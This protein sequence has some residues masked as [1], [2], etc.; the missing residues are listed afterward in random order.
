MP[1]KEAK[2]I[3]AVLKFVNIKKSSI[4][5]KTI[6]RRDR[7]IPLSTKAKFDVQ[8]FLINKNLAATIIPKGSNPQ[9]HII[10]LHGGAY[11]QKAFP[12][13]WKLV[14]KFIEKLNCKL[15]F[16]DYPLAPKNNYK[17]THAMLEQ[18]YKRLTEVYKNDDFIFMG[19]SAG[20]G[21]ALAFLQKL[22]D[23]SGRMP[24]KTVL[25]SPWLDIGMTNPKIKE[26]EEL[27]LMLSVK[28][29]INAGLSYAGGDD[30]HLPF[31]SPIYG[32]FNQLG[33]IAVF[34]GTQDILMPD[35]LLLKEKVKNSDSCFQ[36][37]EYPEMQ[38]D[39]V[40]LPIPEAKKAIDEACHY[41]LN[42]L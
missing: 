30:V 8:S 21:L 34:Y 12:M 39:F 22:K 16:I 27:D 42:E 23:E 2:L 32:K 19:D 10:Y 35:C 3:K 1:S 37:F 36:F 13:H 41:I 26:I 24:T 11:I 38:H 15:T 9:M 17:N 6:K 40:L 5:K 33:K 28:G 29:L 14:H 7:I 31:L 4:F 20:A 18:C 25:F